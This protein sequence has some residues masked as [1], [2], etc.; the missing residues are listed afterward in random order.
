MDKKICK[1]D[2]PF[3]FYW[4]RIHSHHTVRYNFLDGYHPFPTS[5]SLSSLFEWQVEHV[6]TV[7][8]VEE[9]TMLT[10]EKKRRL[11]FL[12]LFHSASTCDQS[13]V[14]INIKDFLA[15]IFKIFVLLLHNRGFCYGCITKPCWNKIKKCVT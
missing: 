11:L 3:S 4:H 12:L 5:L 2:H 9:E 10:I 15:E 6:Y 14:L 7:Q 1:E 8:P 13:A